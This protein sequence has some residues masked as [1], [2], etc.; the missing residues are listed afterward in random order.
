MVFLRE[1][2]AQRHWDAV[3]DFMV[4]GSEFEQ[5]AAL[6]L[7]ATEQYVFISSARVY[8]QTEEPI[9]E[10]TPRLLDV[11]TD[12]EY[13]KTNEYALA[14]ARE[15]D[16]L[17]KSGK[18][19]FTIIRP[20][21]TYNDNRIQLGVF[22]KE[23]WLYRAL[24]G[25]SIVFSSD[26]AD[27]LTT[28]TWGND[29]ATCIASVVGKEEALGEIFHTTISES[30]RWSE[31]LDIYCRALEKHLGRKVTVVMTDKCTKFIYPASKYQIIYCRYFNRSFDNSKI[32][33]FTDVTKFAS[34]EEG[35]TRCM[36][37]FL[38]KPRF[39]AIDWML[40]AVNDR[41]AHEWSSLAE[42]PSMGARLTYICYRLNLLTTYKFLIRLKGLLS[43][44]KK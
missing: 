27:K 30:L 22:E 4:W 33:R 11:C 19:N 24:K 9:T 3:V 21:I 31:V 38:A 32:G 14:K 13:L 18:K 29:V 10:E 2:L 43:L 15:E 6:R 20:S 37:N 34:I 1:V 44:R 7:D 25:R 42:M 26:I 16:L 39:A 41:A 8:A 23:A 12:E 35:L 28:M 36:E 5:V 40:E 17:Q